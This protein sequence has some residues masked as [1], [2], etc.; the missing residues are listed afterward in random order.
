QRS[1]SLTPSVF[2][3]ARLR[4]MSASLRK[5]TCARLPRY[6]R[7][8]PKADICIAAD[9]LFDHLVGSA[10]Q[11]EWKGEAKRPCGVEVDQKFN[12]CGLLDWE[13]R[14]LFSLQNSADVNAGL[15]I[16]FRELGPVTH[17]AAGN[18]EFAP[19]SDC[20]QCV[21]SC[22]HDELIAPGKE[23]VVRADQNRT[24]PLLNES[25]K[26]RIDLSRGAGVRAMDFQPGSAGGLL[27]L[28]RL[29]VSSGIGRIDQRADHTG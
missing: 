22:Q 2:A 14:R 23:K 6:V 15:S 5:R 17:Q 12:F 29:V 10:K 9:F 19:L 16:C 4:V 1:A 18:G 25:C 13:V 21:T 28:S 3:H 24:D 8:V 7:L 20:W 27:Y 26:G 11:R